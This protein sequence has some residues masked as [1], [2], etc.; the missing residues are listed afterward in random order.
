MIHE[1]A[2]C[3]HGPDRECDC[4]KPKPGLLQQIA[5]KY[6]FPLE[7]VPYVGDSLRDLEAAQAVGALPILVKTGKGCTTLQKHAEKIKDILV[8][9]NL[10]GFADYWIK[11]IR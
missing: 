6:Q 4:R 1:I 7:N 5:E 11:N 3:P 10:L 9:D 2:Y 8:F